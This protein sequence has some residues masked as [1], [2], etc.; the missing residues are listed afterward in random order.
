MGDQSQ[1]LEGEQITALGD[2]VSRAS[3]NLSEVV[4]LLGTRGK[5]CLDS[6]KQ[7][8][9]L[10]GLSGLVREVSTV[11]GNAT[12]PYGMAVSLGGNMLSSVITGIDVFFKG[13]FKGYDFSNP[14]EETLFMN[15]FCSFAEI[16][17]DAM[18]FLNIAERPEELEM[19]SEYLVM[20]TGDLE[21]NCIE[22]KAFKIAYQ[23]RE[24]S[25]KIIGRIREDAQ[26]IAPGQDR[27][28]VMFARCTEIHRAI[29]SE[30]SD[31]QQFFQLIKTYQNPLMSNND[32]TLLQDVLSASGNLK[33]LFPRLEQCWQLD[34]D[35][36]L[37]IS[38]DFNNFLRDDI[39]P[40][41]SSIFEQQMR[42]FQNA[43]N[44]KYV[45]PLGDYMEKS[46]DRL[47]WLVEEEKN[48]EKEITDP[49][50]HE[51]ARM[52]RESN[53]KLKQRFADELLPK[54]L[55]YK[56]RVNRRQLKKFS[57]NYDKFQSSMIKHF[58]QNPSFKGKNY[59][60]L[61]E[62][63]KAKGGNDY[64]IFVAEENKI[65]DQFKL[66]LE[67]SHSINRYCEYARYMTLSD[68][69]LNDRCNQITAKL[70]Q[71]YSATMKANPELELP[72]PL[73]VIFAQSDLLFSNSRTADFSEHV[74]EWIERGDERWLLRN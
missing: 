71:Q 68:I 1:A 37:K 21:N 43:A 23:A 33:T 35:Q 14:D 29:H 66:A 28:H 74:R 58:G 47:R 61:K 39:L 64:R 50:H 67:Q 30:N 20:K 36:R 4:Q 42:T 59:S 51:S 15:Q 3:T 45:S 2:L 13:F 11:V 9:F 7:G 26:I 5:Q 60:E 62:F 69:R 24:E 22:C 56:H 54:Y 6:G 57:K 49:N 46:L 70:Q 55:Q 12:G 72:M 25:R 65:S 8:S 53:H 19:L 38:Q 44:K 32:A 17:K 16:Q 63:L 10:S 31:L 18:D 41:A 73:T 48:V 27:D 40:L 52:V 34:Y